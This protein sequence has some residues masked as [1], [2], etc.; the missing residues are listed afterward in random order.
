M[1]KQWI[2]FDVGG[3]ITDE[4]HFTEWIQ[5]HA[6]QVIKKYDPTITLKKVKAAR[7]AA[8]V[9]PGNLNENMIKV[10]LKGRNLKLAL[11]EWKEIRK[12]GPT[13]AQQQIVRPE[14]LSVIR[15]LSKNY[16][17]GI[18]ANQHKE[19]KVKLKKAGI[20]KYFKQKDVSEDIGY[21]KPDPR[22]FK[23]VL[24]KVKADPKTSFLID[25]N[26]ERS[27][28]PAK[29]LKMITVWRKLEKRKAPKGTADYTVTSL[30]G[31]LNIF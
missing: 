11:A 18:I 29:K 16:N 7:P 24:K 14:A 12:N 3:V 31:L 28:I 8:S 25:D 30:K 27:I 21:S 19:I 23:V 1:K 20:L 17:L 5:K 10:F 4:S 26:L 6:T 9:M 13:H 22:F 2:F 15:E